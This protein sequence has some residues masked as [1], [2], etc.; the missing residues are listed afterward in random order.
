MVVKASANL[1]CEKWRTS[2]PRNKR[3]PQ[4]SQAGR[5]R[6]TINER[7][8]W[9]AAFSS[10]EP[11]FDR[12]MLRRKARLQRLSVGGLRMLDGEL[13]AGQPHDVVRVATVGELQGTLC[14]PLQHAPELAVRT[15]IG[16]DAAHV[17][18]H[19]WRK[20]SPAA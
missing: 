15:G 16:P 17:C 6:I 4:A 13:E 20:T 19:R 12:R 8:E 10:F 3:Q 2:A 5:P 9:L 7:A 18:A 11:S 1:R 14:Q